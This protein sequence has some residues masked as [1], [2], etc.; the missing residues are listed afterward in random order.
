MIIPRYDQWSTVELQAGVSMIKFDLN[1]SYGHFAAN[2]E[3]KRL[4]IQRAL[5]SLIRA[6]QRKRAT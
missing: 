4:K 3:S 6:E 5:I 2:V 1:S